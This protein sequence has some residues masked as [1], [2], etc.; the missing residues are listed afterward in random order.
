MIL[1]E[2]LA[3]SV[4]ILSYFKQLL[5]VLENDESIYCISAWNDQVS[6][7]QSGD[8]GGGQ[9]GERGCTVQASLGASDMS[10]RGFEF[11]WF[12]CSLF[13]TCLVFSFSPVSL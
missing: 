2:D 12:F 4:D 9:W 6:E 11:L 10:D 8:T 1:E 7:N 5:P 3:I 13:L